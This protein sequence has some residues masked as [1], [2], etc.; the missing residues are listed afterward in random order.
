M[1]VMTPTSA[2]PDTCHDTLKVVTGKGTARQT[3]R[4]DEDL[5]Q[6]FGDA[7]TATGSDRSAVL[8]E[9]MRRYVADANQALP[10]HPNE[11]SDD[12]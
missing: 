5:W 10:N 8:R 11:G 9:F 3:I 4:V 7:A 2:T 1:G 12:E 6:R